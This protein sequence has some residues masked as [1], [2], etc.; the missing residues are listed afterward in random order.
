[1]KQFISVNDV[2]DVEPL[3]KEAL[4][5]K[6]L[7]QVTDDGKGKTL[8]LFFMNPSLRTRLSTQKA[9]HNL[10]MDVISMNLNQDGWKIEFD[11]GRIMDGESQEHIKDAVKVMSGYCDVIGVR[12]FAS[13]ENK[14]KDY[15]EEILNAF[16]EYSEVPVISLESATRHP[17]QSLADLVTIEELG[18]SKPR[19]VVS[20]APHPKSLP[21]AVPNSFLEWVQ[22]TDAE[23]VLTHPKG[24]GLSKD[25]TGDIAITHDQEE[26]FENAD[27]VYVKS[28]SSFEDYGK[29]AGE[30]RE[31]IVNKDKMDLTNNAHFMHCLPIRRNVI[32][33]DA[34]ID[35]SMIY[36]QAKNREYAAQAVLKRILNSK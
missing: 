32:A 5:L 24:Y 14:E 22:H 23:V 6:K 28:W 3:V 21:Q 15:N 18:I 20:W 1:M 2:G 34:V 8:G 30:H 13:L 29:N 19:V 4:E 11:H 36:E 25:F 35:D 33:T 9:A 7:P 27:V 26:A 10:G 17:L 12:T 16:V 31:W